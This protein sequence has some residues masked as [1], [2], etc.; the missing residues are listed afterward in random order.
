MDLRLPEDASVLRAAFDR[1]RV[2]HVG[3]DIQRFYCE[4][5][6]GMGD[7]FW[8]KSI[9]K[10]VERIGD[11][12][13][14]TRAQLPPVWVNH[15]SFTASGPDLDDCGVIRGV[16]RLWGGVLTHVFSTA[17]QRARWQVYGTHAAPGDVTVGKPRWDGFE[18]TKLDSVLKA[19]GA[20]TLVLT[21]F[22]TDQCV[23]D[24][25]QSAVRRGY[26][27]FVVADLTRP[28]DFTPKECW[29]D[30][31]KVGARVVLGRDVQALA[32]AR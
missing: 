6:H 10:T 24:T 13:R 1:A 2:A 7:Q 31:R 17:A 21:G 25:A 18:N 30:L 32:V 4:P 22:F 15:T 26:E 20:D 29:Y 14:A 27:V 16:G 12:T 3:I 23:M 8:Y 11:F 5:G 19:K 9:G 28:S